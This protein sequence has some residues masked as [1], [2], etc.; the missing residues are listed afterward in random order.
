MDFPTIDVC[1]ICEGIRPEPQNKNLLLG[2]FGI[3]PHVK[4]LLRNFNLPATL[5]FIFCG[6]RGSAGRF[7]VSLRLTDPQGLVVSNLNTVP[8]IKG[9]ELGDRAA[10]NIFMGFQGRLGKPGKYKVS[11]IVNGAEHYATTVDILQAP[12]P[13]SA[14]NLLQ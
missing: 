10:T 13:Q 7:D 2:F 9:G 4:V 3:A 8:E 12:S 6:G 1:I 11:L 5:C 14:V